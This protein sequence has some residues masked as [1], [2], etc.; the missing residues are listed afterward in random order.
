[1]SA[2]LEVTKN[3]QFVSKI[4]R[5]NDFVTQMLNLIDNIV[6]EYAEYSETDASDIESYTYVQAMALRAQQYLKEGLK[7]KKSDLDD[8]FKNLRF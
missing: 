6:V 4:A 5:K 7:L 3:R 8:M 2:P 1:M